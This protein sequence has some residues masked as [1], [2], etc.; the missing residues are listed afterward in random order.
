MKF[1]PATGPLNNDPFPK[2]GDTSMPSAQLQ[3]LTK[4]L[5]T[6][7][8]PGLLPKQVTD[9]ENEF[10]A[11]LNVFFDSLDKYTTK[12]PAPAP[13]PDSPA[14]TPSYLKDV[15]SLITILIGEVDA[16]I[17]SSLS[18]VYHH[19]NF[20]DLES[21]WRG[22]NYLVNN[23]ETGE[24]LKIKVLN[25]SKKELS[26]DLGNESRAYGHDQSALFKKVYEE[27]YGQLGGSPYG[28]LVGDY[29]FDHSPPDVY[30]LKN[31][32]EVA[33][34]AH[35]PFVAGA[36]PRMFKMN[37]F[38]DLGTP[39]DLQRIFESDDYIPWNTE[40][41]SAQES[42]YVALALPRVLC[43][44]PYGTDVDH[45][46]YPVEEFDFVEDV[47][48][49][50]DKK[51]LWMN[52]AWTY[53][54]RLTEA[55]AMYGWLARTR[56]VDTGGLVEGLPFY[57]FKTDDGDWAVKPP[58]QCMISDRREFELSTLG[59]L[60]LVYRKH[61]VSAAFLGAQSC[62]KPALYFEAE[63]NANAALSAK[64]NL[65]L[66][67]SRFAHYLK[68]M[69]RNKIGSFM[70]VKDCSDW[71][72]SWINNY[73]VDPTNVGEMTKAKFPLSNARVAVTPVEG[74]PGWYECV[75]YLRPHFQLE[76]LTASLRLVA[77]V[78]QLSS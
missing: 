8:P 64:F 50:D 25:A 14:A 2:H 48:G 53:V 7:D 26:E 57:Q 31:I 70:E 10:K 23:T 17:S 69:A 20:Q 19:T 49:N 28:V 41:R 56:G 29:E 1:Q 55:Y 4:K 34:D 42:R 37:S 75:A 6:I 44:P 76:T 36:S 74:K 32:A 27:E 59:F 16:E 45:G 61:S 68:V 63:A 62:Q 60:P 3:E 71:L 24:L 73:V 33:A 77:E 5:H 30:L 9:E 46:C 43:R 12:H 58:V 52:A 35:A 51:F 47:A 13:S 18:Q 72:N 21:T 22:L 65:M 67:V 66:C 78:P 39:R 11:E 40:F 54:A 38:A 15:Q